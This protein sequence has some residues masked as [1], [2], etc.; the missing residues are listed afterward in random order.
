MAD[1]RNL[2]KDSNDQRYGSY[3]RTGVVQKQDDCLKGF[4]AA[5]WACFVWKAW[6]VALTARQIE[7]QH[8]I[9]TRESLA[10]MEALTL[11]Y[12]SNCIA[13]V[14][15]VK[16]QTTYMTAAALGQTELPVVPLAAGERPGIFGGGWI[17]RR[18]HSF[19]TMGQKSH[20]SHRELALIFDVLQ[21]K[22]G[23]PPV[24]LDFIVA[25]MEDHKAVLTTMKQHLGLYGVVGEGQSRKFEKATDEAFVKR[26]HILARIKER[27]RE[28]VNLVYGKQV[29]NAHD[30]VP[31]MNAGFYGSRKNGGAFG[32]LLRGWAISSGYCRWNR[33]SGHWVLKPQE[34]REVDQKHNIIN[35]TIMSFSVPDA[36]IV[37]ERRETDLPGL[38]LIPSWNQY[39]DRRVNDTLRLGYVEARVS[40]IVEPDKV[41]TIT[42]S[43]EAIVYRALAFQKFAHGILRRYPVFEYSGMPVDSKSL[44]SHFKDSWDSLGW[45][46]NGDYKGATDNLHPDLGEE[47][48]NAICDTVKL[49]DGQL[50]NATV[51][52]ELLL[53]DLLKHEIFYPGEKLDGQGHRQVW[54]QLMGSPTSF[55][56]L[57]IVNAAASSVGLG[58]SLEKTM[59]GPIA[60]NGDD[61]VAWV[62]DPAQYEDWKY[63]T[64]CAG[65]ELSPGKNYLTKDAAIINSGIFCPIIRDPRDAHSSR[66]S[67]LLGFEEI[68][69][70]NQ[71]LLFGF[72]KKGTDAGKDLKVDM[73][74]HELGS[75]LREL[76]LGAGTPEVWHL[77]REEF[78]KYHS[79]VLKKLPPGVSKFMSPELGGAGVP[80]DGHEDIPERNRKYAA[81]VACLDDKKRAALAHIPIAGRGW[82]DNELVKA[83][84]YYARVVGEVQQ[85]RDPWDVTL[86]NWGFPV[87]RV[88]S[89]LG[90]LL[91]LGW[92]LNAYTVWYSSDKVTPLDLDLIY[93]FRRPQKGEGLLIEEKAISSSPKYRI[94]TWTNHV[95]KA[96]TKSLATS[97]KPMTSMALSRWVPPSEWVVQFD[98]L[99]LD[100]SRNFLWERKDEF[101]I[102]ALT[103]LGLFPSDPQHRTTSLK[104]DRLAGRTPAF[105]S[106]LSDNQHQWNLFVKG[107]AVT[108]AWKI[109]NLKGKCRSV[110][111]GPENLEYSWWSLVDI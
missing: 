41:R 22:L 68:V 106:W 13:A 105:D 3:L 100:S 99:R 14:K 35:K 20:R 83:E 46:L 48:I 45:F 78:L 10:L 111:D 93:G 60:V 72:E 17:Y 110:L 26:E 56:V 94:D 73:I 29:F 76:L 5:L 24:S 11:K 21:S 2:L 65:L 40:P 36:G 97:L 92:V 52:K 59:D 90:N 62:S 38:D 25:A 57:C 37:R 67:N 55:Y 54:G 61:I 16:M 44:L 80:W 8:A 42:A 107:E 86:E 19:M 15:Y 53:A 31:S 81:Y 63:A 82:L 74:P 71:S 98:A 64:A 91:R 87:Q 50:L 51:W 84:E 23:R 30:H 88:K 95:R 9:E 27:I 75:R 47:V 43:E 104:T 66:D 1:I 101:A 6:F 79:Q 34:E 85:D 102:T 96:V 32:N 77:W 39:V 7:L 28:I 103:S 108:P 70:L 109:Y 69:P 33:V 12:F 58:Y 18:C 49:P 4:E 89:S